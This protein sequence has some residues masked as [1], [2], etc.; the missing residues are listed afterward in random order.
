MALPEI[1][2]SLLSVGLAL[3][4]VLALMLQYRAFSF[5]RYLAKCYPRVWRSATGSRAEASRAGSFSVAGGFR[6]VLAPPT[7]IEQSGE[8]R[9]LKREE[10]FRRM[11]SEVFFFYLV[12]GA[13]LWLLATVTGAIVLVRIT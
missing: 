4:L 6:L 1:V 10:I 3:V 9:N 8:Y 7:E 12:L 2:L 13:W 5:R 11:R